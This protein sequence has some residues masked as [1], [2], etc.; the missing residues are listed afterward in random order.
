LWV[1]PGRKPRPSLD[2]DVGHLFVVVVVVVVVERERE[3]TN[4]RWPSKLPR[5][6]IL[7]RRKGNL[8]KYDGL[9]GRDSGPSARVDRSK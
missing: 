1:F 4:E 3:G 7:L 9:T 2:V 6:S 5:N 8:A